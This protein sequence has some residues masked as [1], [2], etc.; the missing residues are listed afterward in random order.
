MIEDL[1]HIIYKTVLEANRKMPPGDVEKVVAYTAGVDR[2]RVKL[3]IR[4]LVGQGK[5]SYTYV[6]GH[7][8][9]ERSFERPVRLSRRIVIKPPPNTI[10][11]RPRGGGH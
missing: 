4:D 2:K 8:F 11:T 1:K 6:H 9:L 7:S 3:A 5:L 10:P